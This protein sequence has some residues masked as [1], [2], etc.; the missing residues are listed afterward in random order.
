MQPAQPRSDQPSGH[1][2]ELTQFDREHQATRLKQLL[3]AAATYAIAIPLLLLAYLAGLIALWPA[4]STVALIVAF[5]LV[6]FVTFKTG[7]NLK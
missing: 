3:S 7:A 1:K 6:L 5:N 4:L 2:I